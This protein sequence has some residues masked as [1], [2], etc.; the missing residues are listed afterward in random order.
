MTELEKMTGG[1]WYD[2]RD[3]ELCSMSSRAKDL[4]RFYNSLPAENTGLHK[5]ILCLLLG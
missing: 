5:E 4:M 1:E 3:P 2:T